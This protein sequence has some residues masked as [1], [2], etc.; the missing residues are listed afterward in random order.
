MAAWKRRLLKLIG[1]ISYLGDL[2]RFRV[3]SQLGMHP[4]T[5]IVVAAYRGYGR[6]DMVNIT[7]RVL[8]DRFIQTDNEDERLWLNLT[9]TV[10]RFN[11][12]EING[13]NLHISIGDND[14]SLTTDS[15][16]YFNLSA[17]LPH[18]VSGQ[19]NG[20]W[21][22]APIH[23]ESTPWQAVN[24]W[25]SAEIL[26]PQNANFGIISDLDDTVIQTGVTSILKLR[27]IYNT[28]LK[29]ARTRKT[30][31]EVNAFFKALY[32]HG[33][34]NTRNPIFYVSNSP[35]NLYDLLEEFLDYNGFPKG[36]ILLR[37]FGLSELPTSPGHKLLKVEHILQT[38][39]N[40]KFL[41]IG[42]S[43][44]RDTDIYLQIARQYPERI[45][46]ILIHDV[47]SKKRALRIQKLI[48]QTP[49]VNILLFQQYRQAAAYCANKSLLSFDDFQDY[50]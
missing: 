9:N 12:N 19:S 18:P 20:N 37:D 46:A 42:D 35:W 36:P 16:G 10:K 43:G 49:E 25:S 29:S 11:S 1:A 15:E 21:L 17:P 13:A 38:Y 2:L 27:T 44:E 45:I 39:P 32:E 22:M 8:Q 40:L 23:L 24:I 33:A 3:S 47:R 31:H 50:L 34:P 28:I 4:H 7:G 14:F 48:K 26:I 30:F 41:L 5:P 6:P